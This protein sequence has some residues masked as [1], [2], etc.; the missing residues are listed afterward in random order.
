[1]EREAALRAGAAGSKAE[2]LAREHV[3]NAHISDQFDIIDGLKA[4]YYEPREKYTALVEYTL[5]LEGP[6]F[7]P[8]SSSSHQRGLC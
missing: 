6:S 5:D 7:A 8:G 2:A 1:M 3:L 4:G